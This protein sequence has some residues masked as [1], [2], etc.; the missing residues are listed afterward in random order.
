M[1]IA[2]FCNIN[3][4]EF[5]FKVFYLNLINMYFDKIKISLIG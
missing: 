3:I 2:V 4:Y 5:S 1:E